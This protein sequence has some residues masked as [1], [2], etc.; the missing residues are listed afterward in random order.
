MRCYLSTRVHHAGIKFSLN[1][2][3]DVPLSLWYL[4]FYCNPS[5][6]YVVIGKILLDSL[7]GT[8]M[9]Y[10]DYINTYLYY[11]RELTNEEM[12]TYKR[13]GNKGKYI[14]TKDLKTLDWPW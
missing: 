4:T 10:G 11:E 12:T 2:E 7:H 13:E 5:T 8:V 6:K 3:V 14:K 9:A 1:F